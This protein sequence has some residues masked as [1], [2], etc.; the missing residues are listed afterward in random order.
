MKK[1][2]SYIL[3]LAVALTA[4]LAFSSCDLISEQVDYITGNKAS[5][6]DGETT[7]EVYRSSVKEIMTAECFKQ[8]LS[9]TAVQISESDTYCYDFGVLTKK[10]GHNESMEMCI[11][12]ES[13]G[14]KYKNDIRISYVGGTVYVSMYGTNIMG[15]MSYEDYEVYSSGTEFSA[16]SAYDG[17]F[18][19]I[20]EEWFE[21]SAF[22]K[23]ERGGYLIELDVST[24][25]FLEH[26]SE[27]LAVED[28]L[29]D[30]EVSCK[31]YVSG[32]GVLKEAV[33][34]VNEKQGDTDVTMQMRYTV[35]SLGTAVVEAPETD[36]T[37]LNT[38]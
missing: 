31:L 24:D 37:W 13:N 33:F 8:E 15:K 36:D 2:T 9:V 11:E 6:L 5:D 7:Y 20:P 30:A 32:D 23:E 14:S 3:C 17:L 27:Y 21:S 26:C 35:S 22:V 25:K 4:L 18:L 1:T 38:D 16:F 34:V 29:D 10:D 28:E 19:N 12:V